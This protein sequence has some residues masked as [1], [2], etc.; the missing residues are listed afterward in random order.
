MQVCIS[1]F[2][3]LPWCSVSPKAP[4]IDAP[5]N[6][7]VM[8]Q[9]SGIPTVQQTILVLVQTGPSYVGERDEVLVYTW[10]ILE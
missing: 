1:V 4:F 5:Q 2:F 9:A 3:F 6:S 7:K 10:I 8:T